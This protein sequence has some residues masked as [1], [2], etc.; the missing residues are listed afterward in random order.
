MSPPD[1]AGAPPGTNRRHHPEHLAE[2]AAKEDSGPSVPM[3]GDRLG[4]LKREHR[5]AQR[6]GDPI[7]ERVCS[8]RLVRARIAARRRRM[9]LAGEE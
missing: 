8:D 9:L 7:A 3:A 1:G 6:R 4:R 5:A 2:A